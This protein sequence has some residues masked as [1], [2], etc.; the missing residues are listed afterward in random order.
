MEKGFF[1]EL[2]DI[3]KEY[4]QRT[5]TSYMLDQEATKFLPGGSTR[6]ATD[7]KPYPVYMKSGKGCFLIDAD[8][9]EYIDFI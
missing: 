7:S 8:E 6:S 3:E 9:N 1:G 5:K 4:L 2:T